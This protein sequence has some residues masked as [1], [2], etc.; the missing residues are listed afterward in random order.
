MWAIGATLLTFGAT[1]VAL[2]A[3]QPAALLFP[4]I[5]ASATSIGHFI[6]TAQAA[7]TMLRVGKTADDAALLAPLLDRF[8][9]WHTA[10][11]SLQVLT[12]FL[13]LWA[14]LVAR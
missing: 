4:L 3:R 5:L 14:L 12:F 6:A 10:R 8:A 1:V 13:L 7:P 2:A 11:A 9:R